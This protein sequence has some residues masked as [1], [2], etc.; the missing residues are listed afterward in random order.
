MFVLLR[1][2]AAAVPQ[3]LHVSV[4]LVVVMYMYA[5]V[6]VALFS[7]VPDNNSSM[8]KYA[9]RIRVVLAFKPP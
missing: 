6:G 7:N 1:T 5:V 2:L 8:T 9:Y 4:L 3:L